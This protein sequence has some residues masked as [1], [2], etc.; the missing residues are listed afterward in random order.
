MK[1]QIYKE[2]L[3]HKEKELQNYARV[4]EVTNNMFKFLCNENEK[5]RDI[6]KQKE[7]KIEEYTKEIILCRIKD[8]EYQKKMS[9]YQEEIETIL[10]IVNLSFLENI[11]EKIKLFERSSNSLLR[12]G[13][14]TL[15]RK[16]LKKKYNSN[17]RRASKR[18]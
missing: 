18:S 1:C 16:E 3:I 4:I 11:L 5:L 7:E 13:T 2:C 10:G 9:N 17:A 8:S 6:I 14:S 12:V 15:N